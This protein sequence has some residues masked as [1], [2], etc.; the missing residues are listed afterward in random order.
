MSNHQHRPDRHDKRRDQFTPP[1]APRRGWSWTAAIAVAGLVLASPV[2][3]VTAT[4][5]AGASPADEAVVAVQG[6]VRLDVAQFDDGQARFYRHTNAA[7]KEIRFFVL[8]SS[9]GVI[10]AAFDTCDVCYRERKGYRQTGDT[11]V[12]NNC[13]QVFR[14]VD[15]NVLQGGC[16]PVPLDRIVHNGQVVLTAA[17]LGAGTFYF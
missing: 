17:A 3:Y 15:I 10:R 6:D 7:G 14:S 12:C 9:D 2:I 13:N 11:M 16:N 8:R 5:Q 4:R 1:P